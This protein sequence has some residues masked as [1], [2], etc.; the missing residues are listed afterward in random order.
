MARLHNA[1]GVTETVPVQISTFYTRPF[2]V[3]N[4]DFVEALRAQI[5]DEH[6]QRLLS[7]CLIGNIDQFSD[8]TDLREDASRRAGLRRLYE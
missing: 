3:L 5:K 2:Q 4:S 6:V 8:S 7:R 1:L